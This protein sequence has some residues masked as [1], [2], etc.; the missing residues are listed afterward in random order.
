MARPDR[1]YLYRITHIDNLDFILE[2]GKL[3]CP[4][5]ANSDPKYI[6]IGDPTL[7]G[8]RSSKQININPKG[9][10]TDYVAFYFGARSPMLYE[11]QN[12]FNGVTKRNPEEIIYLVTTY[13]K[14]T[15]YECQYVF[16]D[17]HGYHLMSQF[18]NDEDSLDE[19]D[20]ET[21]NLVHWNDTE[22]DP[23]RKRRKQAEFLV[24]KE[25]PLS[26]LIAVV[27]YNQP[28]KNEILAK[29]AG[30]D[31]ICSVIVEPNWYY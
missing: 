16:S 14:I 26:A 21:V 29:F 5:H 7:I 17:G 19:V 8:S 24:F 3:T 11:I 18:F 12:G 22:D 1:I 20:W 9:N 28:V 15:E 6:G 4:S 23:D 2:L 27:V 30:Y 13:K 31:L 10:F 25:L